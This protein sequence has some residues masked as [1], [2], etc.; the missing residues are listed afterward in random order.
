[1]NKTRVVWTFEEVHE[2]N[3]DTGV[4][5]MN[6]INSIR[7]CKNTFGLDINKKTSDNVDTIMNILFGDDERYDPCIYSE[8]ISDM[9]IEDE[10]EQNMSKEEYK[11]K[12]KVYDRK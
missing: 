3:S 6:R 1:M 12:G 4:N 8:Q 10:I 2:L 7:R 5:P 9:I 11:K